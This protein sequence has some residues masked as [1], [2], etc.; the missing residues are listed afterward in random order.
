[1][2]Q[3]ASS[4]IIICQITQLSSIGTGT[5]T[6]SILAKE[7][8]PIFGYILSFSNLCRLSLP[9]IFLTS[10]ILLSVIQRHTNNSGFMSII[11]APE[12]NKLLHFRPNPK[13]NEVIGNF[14]VDFTRLYIRPVSST[15]PPLSQNL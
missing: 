11:Y 5:E 1:M 15:C 2:R 8:S 4:H 14:P 9:I 12:L 10:H 6:V 13:S 7:Y 3:I